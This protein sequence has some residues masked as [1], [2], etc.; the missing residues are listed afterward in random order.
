MYKKDD[1]IILFAPAG[2]NDLE[3]S[4]INNFTFSIG[5]KRV[6]GPGKYTPETIIFNAPTDIFCEKAT[7]SSI[8]VN[9]KKISI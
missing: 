1:L 2:S 8:E 7:C 3:I 9:I 6:E 4:D 5:L